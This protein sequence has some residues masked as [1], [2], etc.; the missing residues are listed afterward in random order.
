MQLIAATV[1]G[2]LPPGYAFTV[3]AVP[4]GGPDS[5]DC[6]WIYVANAARTEVD[7]LLRDF[8]ERRAAE[9]N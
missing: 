2:M 9:R 7:R 3:I 5:R 6:Q 4:F 1:K 8:L